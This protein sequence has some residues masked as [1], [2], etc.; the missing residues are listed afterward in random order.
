MEN[1]EFWEK[2]R[3]PPK[4]AL[5]KIQAGRLKGMSDINPQWRLQMMTEVFGPIGIGWKYNID[6]LWLED[7]GGANKCAFAQVSLCVMDNDSGKWSE[8]IPG[9]GGSM[10]IAQESKG[11]HTSDECFKMA[12]TDAL[13]VAM[14]QLGVAAD[15]YMGIMDGSKYSAPPPKQPAPKPDMQPDMSSDE[16]AAFINSMVG[17]IDGCETV[18]GL[19]SLY[20]DNEKLIKSLKE[21]QKKDLLAYFGEAKSRLM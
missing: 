14:K 10:F 19:E 6:R 18:K 11:P 12:V 13:S 7:G 4:Q 1:L 8:P 15:I 5:K 3:T 2:L 21:G 16:A 9:I 20:K 17:L